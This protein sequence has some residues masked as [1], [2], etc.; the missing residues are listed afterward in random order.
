MELTVTTSTWP[1]W[2]FFVAAGVAGLIIGFLLCRSI[3]Y[4]RYRASVDAKEKKRQREFVAI[5]SHYLLNPITVIQ[6]ATS[7]LQE[8]DSIDQEERAKLYE[9]IIRGEQRLWITA[10]QLILVN[11]LDEDKL[12]VQVGAADLNDVVTGAIAAV[13]TFAR[14]KRVTMHFE[15]LT[16]G[17]SEARFDARRMKQALIAIFDNAVKFSAEGGAVEATLRIQDKLCEIVIKDNGVGMSNE[18]M[19]QLSSKFFRGNGIYNFDYEGLGLGLFIARTIIAMHGG[20]MT[21]DSKPKQGTVV[22]IDFP[23]E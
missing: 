1:A 7:R 12:N 13:D 2:Y 16:R 5:A 10:E 3:F 6:T 22:R 9:A 14:Q 15:D 11:Q 19:Q 21:I 17:A 20:V 8:A 4:G 18:V 23:K